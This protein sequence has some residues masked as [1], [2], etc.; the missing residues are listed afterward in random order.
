MWNEFVPVS[1]II[2]SIPR[3]YE[4]WDRTCYF[5][6]EENNTVEGHNFG[7]FLENIEMHEVDLYLEREMQER[8]MKYERKKMLGSVRFANKEYV[9]E[10]L[11]ELP[12]MIV[13]LTRWVAQNLKLIEENSHQIRTR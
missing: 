3:L 12:A 5:Y 6:R 13:A 7:A 1:L 2:T 11:Q 10:Q 4:M 8:Q 9:A